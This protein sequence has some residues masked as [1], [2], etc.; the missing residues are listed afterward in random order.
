[1]LPGLWSAAS[2]MEAQQQQLDAISNDLANDSTP[3][4]QST[5][6]GFHDL[7][8][9]SG[10][11]QSGSTVATGAGAA[12]SVTG[13]S[14]L[15]GTIE[16]TGQPLDVAIEGEG[17][18]EVRRPDG[19][20]GL[21]RNGTLQV[22]SQGRLTTNLGMPVQPPVTLPKGVAP[23][24]VTIGSDGTV[25]VGTRKLG[26]IAIV[27]VP[28]PDGLLADG[29]SLFST[30]AASGAMRPAAGA[31]LEQGALEASNVDIS[32][33]MVKMIDAEQGYNLA[34]KAIQYQQQM[35]QIANQLKSS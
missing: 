1:M 2:G 14:Q 21:T 18:L 26:K 8:Y 27:T 16:Q 12:A 23:S 35:G 31:T 6:V 10:G 4:Y 13:R 25:S 7:L 20:I 17:Y 9:A 28:A 11:A 3:G 33:D 19:T 32:E 30:T 5:I 29:D 34:S 15:Q 24:D 22:D